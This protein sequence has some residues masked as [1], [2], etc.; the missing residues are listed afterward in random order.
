VEELWETKRPLENYNT[1]NVHVKCLD[2]KLENY[3]INFAAFLYRDVGVVA[4]QYDTGQKCVKA[5]Y[6][7]LQSAKL[8]AQKHQ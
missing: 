5:F 2:C 3:K 7:E 8:V 6:L 1:N 4:Y